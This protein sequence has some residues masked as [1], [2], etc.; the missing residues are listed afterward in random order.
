M[1]Y[2]MVY[3]SRN[4][5]KVVSKRGRQN[6]KV[7]YVYT[8]SLL[9]LRIFKNINAVKWVRVHGGHD[10]AGILNKNIRV[11][12]AVSTI[13]D[14]FWLLDLQ[15]RIGAFPCISNEGLGKRCYVRKRL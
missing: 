8:H 15:K 3:V 10:P 5:R 7:P 2:E 9:A 11:R 14:E 1:N 12:L 6:Q 13:Y 4:S